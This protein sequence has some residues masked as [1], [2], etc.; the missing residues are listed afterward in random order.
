MHPQDFTE[1]RNRELYRAFKHHFLAACPGTPLLEI[2][3]RSVKSPVSRYYVSE[4]EACNKVF[5]LINTGKI[6][7]K[8][9][10]RRKMYRDIACRA[11][12]LYKTFSGKTLRQCVREVV[13]QPAPEFYLQ[14]AS[15]RTIL[16]RYMKQRRM[17]QK[18]RPW[19]VSFHPGE[20]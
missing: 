16:S 7:V 4:E 11:L 14:P 18:K 13:N 12:R 8:T 6:Y 20:K 17:E 10:V 1:Q 9:P 2:Y 3:R 5:R 15:A 19:G